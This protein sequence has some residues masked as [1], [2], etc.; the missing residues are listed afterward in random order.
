MA[1]GINLI[2]DQRNGPQ[3]DEFCRMKV[4]LHIPHRNYHQLTENDTFS[5]SEVFNRDLA[6]KESELGDILGPSVD[7]LEN[8]GVDDDDHDDDHD[9]EEHLDDI[10]PDWMILSDLG[11][12]DVDRNND[13]SG[14]VR[15]RYP[16]IDSIDLVNFV[17]HSRVDDTASAENQNVDYP[18]NR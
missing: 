15:R 14:D 4:L 6:D 10:R 11:L 2:V 16:D 8:E 3:W 13:W 7:K 1:D 18:I 5:W 12:R 17:Q 9:P